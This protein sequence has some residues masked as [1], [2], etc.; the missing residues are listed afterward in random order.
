[1]RPSR[2]VKIS[3]AELFDSLNDLGEELGV[4][5]VVA[6]D[7]A[8]E[9]SKVTWINFNALLAYAYDNLRYVSFY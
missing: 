8:Q 2:A 1:L 7:E 5:I 3:I 6:I 4:S 9:L